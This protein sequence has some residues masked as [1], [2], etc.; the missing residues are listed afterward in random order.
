[1]HIV[2]F[3]PTLSVK[4]KWIM[5]PLLSTTQPYMLY[6]GS[7]YLTKFFKNS[8]EIIALFSKNDNV[9][10]YKVRMYNVY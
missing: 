5:S 2:G 1:M 3:E 4:R 7:G 10:L 9:V 8:F 6:V